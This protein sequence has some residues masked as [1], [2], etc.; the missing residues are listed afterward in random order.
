[1]LLVLPSLP[2]AL[3]IQ[4]WQKAGR[5]RLNP[6]K[7]LVTWIGS[8]QLLARLDMAAVPVVSFSVYGSRRRLVIWAW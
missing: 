3:Y 2:A 4:A 7:T 1:M 5:L 6:A 8:Q